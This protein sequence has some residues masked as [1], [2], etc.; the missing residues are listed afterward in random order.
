MDRLKEIMGCLKK[1]IKDL[2]NQRHKARKKDIDLFHQLDDEI[3][4]LKAHRGVTRQLMQLEAYAT[5][6]GIA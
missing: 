4:V 6:K 3:Q 2:S 5:S 1:D